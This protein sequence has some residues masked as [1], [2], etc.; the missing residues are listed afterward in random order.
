MRKGNSSRT[1][2]ETKIELSLNIDGSGKNSINSG[3]GFFDHMLELFSAHGCFDIDLKCTGDIKVDGHHSVEDAGIALGKLFKDLLGDKCGIARYANEVLPMDETLAQVTVDLSGRP[4]FVFNAELSG[5]TGDFDL[6]LVEEF[7]R[8][9][10]T[11]GM[12]TFHVNLLYGKNPHHIAEAIFKAAARA[13]KNA[14]KI[15]SDRIP[16][17]KG[18]LE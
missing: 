15:V 2:K 11:Y 16:S 6:E 14:V 3:V 7:F 17:S 5:K 12:M 18:T 4:F 10:S 1:T 8:A 9:F 13:L